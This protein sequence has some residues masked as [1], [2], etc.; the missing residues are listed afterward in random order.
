M[1]AAIEAY[2]ARWARL[3]DLVGWGQDVPYWGLPKWTPELAALVE[4]VLSGGPAR[5]RLPFGGVARSLASGWV[6]TRDARYAH[7]ARVAYEAEILQGEAANFTLPSLTQSVRLQGWLSS[8]GWVLDSGAFDEACGDRLLAGVAR[9]GERLAGRL[10]PASMNW[11]VAEAANLLKVSLL[12]AD[13]AEAPRWRELAVGALNDAVHRQINADG[14]HRERNPHYHIWMTQ[15]LTVLW[16]MAKAM[17]ELGLRI[18]PERVAAMWDYALLCNRPNGTEN[19]LHDSRGWFS[20]GRPDAERRDREQFLREAG[21]PADLPAPRGWFP[22]AGQ[23]LLRDSWEAGGVYMTFDATRWGEGHCHYSRNSLQIHAYGRTLLADPGVFEY[24]DTPLGNYGR[25]TRAHSTL[26]LNGWNQ[27]QTNPSRAEYR[28]ADGYDLVVADYEGTFHPGPMSMVCAGD[29]GPGIWVSHH[30]CLLWV[31]G[32]AIVV[33]DSFVR[34][35]DRNEPPAQAPLLE[36]NWQLG[37]GPARWDGEARQLVT[38]HPDAN[39]LMLFPV[40]PE[41]WSAAVHTGET[42]PPRG[43]VSSLRVEHGEDIPNSGDPI[44][45]PQLCL[46]LAP[47]RGPR[48]EFVS[49]LVPFRGSAAPGVRAEGRAA[50]LVRPGSLRLSW[51]DG[52]TDEWVWSYRLDLGLGLFGR[53]DTDAA[54]MHIAR[55]ASGAEHGLAAD[56]TYCRPLCAGVADRPAMLRF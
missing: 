52:R 54:L 36:S 19:G 25:S 34:V 4:P 31:H 37:P 23:A 56:A 55:D 8:L 48:A 12:L 50:T 46:S 53:F 26:N 7:A 49:V 44:P 2:R 17:P 41:G 29:L 33:I 45:A 5:P 18:P 38:G 27:A 11:R 15:E 21:L 32:R 14:S 47:M 30:R 16:R 42:N 39:L 24:A 10:C 28:Q 1:T 20:G 3:R 40:L 22:D 35:P 43:F 13:R 51:A 6:A 9:L